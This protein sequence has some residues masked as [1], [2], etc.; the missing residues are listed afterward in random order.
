MLAIAIFCEYQ[1]LIA[2][3]PEPIT[4]A[5]PWSSMRA[6]ESLVDVHFTQGVTSRISP[7]VK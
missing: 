2:P 1:A 4:L 5:T 7:F 6:T 3:S